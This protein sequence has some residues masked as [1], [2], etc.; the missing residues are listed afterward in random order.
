[1]A[2]QIPKLPTK[3]DATSTRF[4]KNMRAMA[5]LV[6]AVRN[7][8]QQIQPGG[9]RRVSN[10]SMPRAP[11]RARTHRPA[12]R[13]RPSSS[14]RLYA[15]NEMYEEWRALH[16]PAWS[17][18]WDAI[19]GRLFML[20]V[21]DARSRPALLFHDGQKVIR[22]QNISIDNHIPTIYLVDSAGVS[23]GCRKTCFLTRRFWPRLPRQRRDVRHGHTAITAIMGMCVAGGA[24]LP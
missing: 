20:I 8:E 12:H 16:Q 6:A 1:M 24:Y 18:A 3:I 23:C 9:G 4:E 10:R 7:E 21:D 22:A 11:D 19:H 15:A 14:S 17:P 2:D 5:E 13:P